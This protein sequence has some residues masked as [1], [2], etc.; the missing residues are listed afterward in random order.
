MPT[1][2]HSCRKARA[3]NAA[4]WLLPDQREVAPLLAS[5][6][7]SFAVA[8]EQQGRTVNSWFDT[9]DWRLYSHSFLLCHDRAAWHLLERE[10]GEEVAV[11]SC[12]EGGQWRFGREFPVSRLRVLLEPLLAERR[13]LELFSAEVTAFSLRVE[14]SDAKTVALVS[15]ETHRI[16]DGVPATSVLRLRGVRGYGREFD[17]LCAFFRDRGVREQAEPFAFF[18][19]GVRRGGR[20]PLDYTSRFRPALRPEMTARQAMTVIYRDLLAT[21][22]RNEDGVIADLDCEFLHDFRVAVRRTRSGLGQVKS[23]LPEKATTTFRAGFSWLG[24]VTGPTRDLDV[25]LHAESACSAWLPEELRP[26]LAPFFASLRRRRATEFA[27][28]IR[29]LR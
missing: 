14:N 26:A 1:T 24:Q 28:L 10:S 6:G 22:R 27:L 17:E 25:F 29:R 20:S 2:G 21:I 8:T 13:L 16:D 9:F 19:Q 15:A 3:E 18:S 12:P 11:L 4:A 7:Q 5:L 23:V